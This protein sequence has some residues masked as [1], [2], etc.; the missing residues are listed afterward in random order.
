[1]IENATLFTGSEKGGRIVG[2]RLALSG[3]A[4][5]PWEADIDRTT[6]ACS[7]YG[8]YPGTKEWDDCL[9]F[10]DARRAKR[11]GF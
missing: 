7:Q 10:V 5:H 3:C 1:M 2:W 9:K 6:Y 4:S 11:P 8:F